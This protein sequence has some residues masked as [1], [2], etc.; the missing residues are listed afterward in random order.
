MIDEKFVQKQNQSLAGLSSSDVETSS[1][2][3][4]VSS[5][6]PDEEKP[7]KYYHLFKS[8]KL[9]ENKSLMKAFDIAF[10][11][12]YAEQSLLNVVNCNLNDSQNMTIKIGIIMNILFNI[13]NSMR[14][15]ILITLDDFQVTFEFFWGMY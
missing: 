9:H 1:Y 12:F 4:S 8:F 10:P 13:L 7:G 3:L 2:S 11:G 15:N 6:I 5:R 14:I